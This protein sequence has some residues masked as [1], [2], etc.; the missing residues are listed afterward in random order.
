[1]TP[2]LIGR[3]DGN[4]TKSSRE[5]CRILRLLRPHHDRLPHAKTGIHG[6]D[7]LQRLMK[8]S[9][10][11]FFQHAVSDCRN[12][13]PTIRLGVYTEYTPVACIMNNF[14]LLTSTDHTC[15]CGSRFKS[16]TAQD[17][18][19]IIARMKIGQSSG[20]SCHL[21]APLFHTFSLPVHHN[22]KHHLD[23]TFS[24]TTTSSRTYTV[25]SS[26]DEPLSH[27]NYES[28]RNPRNT[29]PTHSSHNESHLYIFEDNEG[30]IKM[31]IKGRSPTMRHVSRT[32]RVAPD[33]LFF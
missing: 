28:G 14:S 27:A 16:L 5:T 19:V 24:M 15:A 32:H 12:V 13:V 10:L 2:L 25:T 30:V 17:C 3:Q 18:S 22:T 1:M 21:L 29:S 6:G 7:H 20:Q 33:W 31:T 9:D 8:G 26:A 4:G 11:L 23:K